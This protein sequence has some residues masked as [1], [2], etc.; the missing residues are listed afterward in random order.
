MPINVPLPKVIPDVGPGGPLVTAMRGYNSLNDEML[1]TRM[2]QLENY[3]YPYQKQA[4]VAQKMAQAQYLAPQILTQFL[5]NPNIWSTLDPNVQA[6][7][8]RQL[9]NYFTNPQSALSNIPPMAP[10]QGGVFNRLFGRANSGQGVPGAPPQGAMLPQ[11]TYQG[12]PQEPPIQAQDAGAAPAGGSGMVPLPPLAGVAPAS[13]GNAISQDAIVAKSNGA[14]IPANKLAKAPYATPAAA[15]AASQRVNGAP[16]GNNPLTAAQAESE[17][18]KAALLGQTNAAT[19]QWKALEDQAMHEAD[20]AKT[21]ENQLDLFHRAYKNSYYKGA[22]FGTLPSSGYTAAPTL[23][24]HDL[25]QEQLADKSAN[26]IGVQLAPLLNSGH[27]SNQFMHLVSNL[28]IGRNMDPAAEQTLYDSMKASLDRVQE[29]PSFIRYMRN[30]TPNS[31]A[32][33]ANVLWNAYKKQ[34]PEYDY[35]NEKTL[36]DNLGPQSWKE[37]SSP[38]ALA[39]VRASG[40]YV[41]PSLQRIRVRDPSGKTGTIEARKLEKA[42]SAGYQRVE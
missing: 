7:L 20:S 10:P 29:R 37:F 24:G 1:K 36:P 28:K 34:M 4:E 21:L 25:S 32:P 16:G 14:D 30:N 9:G 31:L 35:E 38:E 11:T 40:N 23:P 33:E 17:G 13:S 12:I 6:A 41:S 2:Q 18:Q 5:S 3:Y 42:L 27:L 8:T 22:R 39:Q 26:N 19:E 15:I